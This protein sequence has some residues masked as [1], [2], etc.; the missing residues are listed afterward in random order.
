MYTAISIAKKT[1][2]RSLTSR[3][4]AL[5]LSVSA[6]GRIALRFSILTKR[7]WLSLGQMSQRA[8]EYPWVLAEVRSIRPSSLVLEV[9]CAES[10]LGY[11]LIAKGFRVVGLDIRTPPFKDKRMVFVRRNILDTKLPNKTFDVI[12]VVSTIEHIGLNVY[13]Q[14]TLDDDGDMKAMREM[15]RIL[16][17]RGTILVTTPYIGDNPFKLNA[18]GRVIERNYNRQRLERIV[19]GF[20]VIKD[21][22]FYPKRL[23]RRYGWTQM[24]REKI[25]KQSF[26]EA[27]LACLVLRKP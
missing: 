27:G 20:Q 11:E 21:E 23:K 6:L 15:W 3:V 18:S 7:L 1:F 4:M 17:P 8:I 9:G 24:N 13:G 19:Q 5:T 16:K 12:V 25:D 2:T 14:L 10:V 26:P 22:Y